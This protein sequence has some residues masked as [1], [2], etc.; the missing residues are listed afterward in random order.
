MSVIPSVH[1]ILLASRVPARVGYAP[2]SHFPHLL[3]YRIPAHSDSPLFLFPRPSSSFSLATVTYTFDFEL[4]STPFLDVAP[5]TYFTHI[6]TIIKPQVSSRLSLR[7][8]LPRSL[9]HS[10]SRAIQYTP[11]PRQSKNK[12]AQTIRR[13]WITQSPLLM[14]LPCL[15]PRQVGPPLPHRP[16]TLPQ[17]TAITSTNHTTS[18]EEFANKV[19]QEGDPTLPPPCV[20]L[21]S[22]LPTEPPP[23]Q[24]CQRQPRS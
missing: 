15:V 4:D 8:P 16:H 5:S 7:H 17:S 22:S 6:N 14:T 11:S 2:P 10:L 9:P 21:G 12:G 1:E 18:N 3:A 19:L 23:R 24:P 20:S 13:T